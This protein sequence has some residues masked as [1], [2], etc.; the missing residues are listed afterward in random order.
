MQILISELS[1]PITSDDLEALVPEGATTLMMHPTTMLEL[2]TRW[3]SD[4][5]D[6]ARQMNPADMLVINNNEILITPSVEAGV[7]FTGGE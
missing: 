3:S 7:I 2:F 4:E 5:L 1:D 6:V